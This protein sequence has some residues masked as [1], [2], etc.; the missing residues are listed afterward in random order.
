MATAP[1]PELLAAAID[2]LTKHGGAG[3]AIIIAIA[4]AATVL[5]RKSADVEALRASHAQLQL[6]VAEID[7]RST[8]RTNQIE[9]K[10]AALT[11]Q[12]SDIRADVKWLV[13]R[14]AGPA[15]PN[16]QPPNP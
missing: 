7:R 10:L 15:S 8:E 1:K 2:L 13:W 3:L 4:S 6:Q 14:F 11:L 9:A 5:E 16:P 12:V